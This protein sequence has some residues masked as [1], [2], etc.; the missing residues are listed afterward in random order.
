MDMKKQVI[1]LGSFSVDLVALSEMLAYSTEW[2]SL[3][4]LF[5][6]SLSLSLSLST[7]NKF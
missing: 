2:V 3:G 1:A 4:Q 6:L 7:R 5:N